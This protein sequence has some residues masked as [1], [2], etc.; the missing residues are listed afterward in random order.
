MTTRRSALKTGLGAGLTAGMASF[1]AARG[2]S[3]LGAATLPALATAANHSGGG[4]MYDTAGGGKLVVH[5]VQHASLV[6]ETPAGVVYV[7]PVG[8]AEL[9]ESLPRPDLIMITHE[10][11]DH[12]DV[13]TL[14]ALA[15]ESTVLVTN[16]A[17]HGMLPDAL[18]SK[19][20]MIGNGESTEALGMNIEAVAAYNLTEERLQFHP[21]GRDNG[22]V[23]DVDGTRVYLSGDTEAVPEMRALE[24]I[25]IAFVCMNLPYTMAVEQ[26]S[27]GVLAFAPRIVYP[28]HYRDSDP[29]AFAV[30]VNE[31]GKDIEVVQGS[32]YA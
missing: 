19:A 23:V 16:P 10:H 4:D 11:G 18:K 6:M 15:G 28:Y 30:L 21:E 17:V 7:D 3:V 26:A 12:Y 13:P 27:E 20:T 22:Y 32:W 8:G 31:G 1:A 14:E 2:L 25:D 9:Y 29:E 24:N 5:P